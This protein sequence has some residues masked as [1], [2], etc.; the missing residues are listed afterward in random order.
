MAVTGSV[1]RLLR[2]RHRTGVLSLPGGVAERRRKI[3]TWDVGF[4]FL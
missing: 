4:L 2:S 1:R 3:L